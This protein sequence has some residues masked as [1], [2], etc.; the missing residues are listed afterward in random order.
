MSC[1][2]SD[3]ML[4]QLQRQGC[5]TNPLPAAVS[6]PTAS[7]GSPSAPSQLPLPAI[8]RVAATLTCCHHCVERAGGAA[9]PA[10]HK[11]CDRPLV[12]AVVAKVPND[13]DARRGCAGRSQQRQ[14]QCQEQRGGAARSRCA[15]GG[16]PRV[17][18]VANGAG[19]R[20]PPRR[21]T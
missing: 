14:R 8:D 19:A 6:P 18:R 5:G 17:L 12:P 11:A 7:C 4:V 13:R 21:A 16:R 1:A 15:G 20:Y 10:A 3:S 9:V 2:A